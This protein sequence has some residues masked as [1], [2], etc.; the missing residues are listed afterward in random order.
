[1]YV[2]LGEIQSLSEFGN[3]P[4]LFP[5]GK[6]LDNVECFGRRRAHRRCI[7][8]ALDVARHSDLALF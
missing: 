2:G 6:G 8:P 1:M 3:A 4:R 5:F 7:L